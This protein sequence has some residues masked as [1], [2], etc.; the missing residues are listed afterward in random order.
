MQ[1]KGEGEDDLRQDAVMEQVFQLC[2]MVL[3]RDPEAAKRKLSIRPYKVIPLSP[4]AG[5][6]EFVTETTPLGEWLLQA[7]PRYAASRSS[8]CV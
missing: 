8:A 1:F 5:M 7:H 6:L 3:K 4:K 2:N